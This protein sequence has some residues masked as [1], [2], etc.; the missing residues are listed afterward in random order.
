MILSALFAKRNKPKPEPTEAD[1]S[2]ALHAKMKQSWD[3]AR[4]AAGLTT[5]E[6]TECYES[7]LGS[8]YYRFVNILDLTEQRHF[9]LSK[10][11]QAIKLGLSDEYLDSI[12]ERL[13]KALD[14]GNTTLAKALVQDMN[15]RRSALTEHKQMMRLGMLYILRHDENPYTFNPVAEAAKLQDIEQDPELRGFFL[16]FAWDL[17]KLMVQEKLAA[18]GVHSQLDFHSLQEKQNE[19]S[20]S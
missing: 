1:K 3:N 12:T 8:V 10:I 13:N 15:H 2:R 18:L 14:Q 19:E 16:A 5:F 9:E 7:A 20:T 6:V 4:T 11:S 17:T